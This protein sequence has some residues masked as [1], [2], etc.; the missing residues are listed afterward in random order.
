MMPKKDPRRRSGF[1]YALLGAGIGGCL[2]PLAVLLFCAVVLRDTGGPLFWPFL[3]VV[4]ALIGLA[5]GLW[6]HAE[7]RK[8]E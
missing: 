8:K 3:S 5:L 1:F 7:F 4:L 6:F 2:I